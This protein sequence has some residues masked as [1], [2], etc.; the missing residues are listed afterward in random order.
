MQLS[1]M[2]FPPPIS[3]GC[4]VSWIRPRFRSRSELDAGIG[5]LNSS[6]R[7]QRSCQCDFR[8][9][10]TGNADVVYIAQEAGEEW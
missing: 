4:V 9:F 3:T 2:T 6:I 5:G 7:L 10:P 8:Y 1:P